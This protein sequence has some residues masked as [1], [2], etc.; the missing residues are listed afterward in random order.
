V[1]ARYWAKQR[2]TCEPFWSHFFNG[3]VRQDLRGAA[4]VI[5]VACEGY[6]SA[7]TVSPAR[8][9][10]MAG[11]VPWLRADLA[12]VSE[13]QPTVVLAGGRWTFLPRDM[14]AGA[15]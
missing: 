2:R 10:K 12:Q 7:I 5:S 3:L 14:V 11:S 13:G 9:A 4:L 8:S 15:A 1:R 6:E